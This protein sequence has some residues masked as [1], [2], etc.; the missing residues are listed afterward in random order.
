MDDALLKKYFEFDEADLFANRSGALTDKQ[1]TRLME[2][3]RFARKAFLIAGIVIFAIGIVPGLIP[4]LTGAKREFSIIWSVV[5]IPIWSF[6]A[7]KVIRMGTA[8]K[9]YL[10]VHKAEGKVNIVKEESY[11]SAMKQT[12]DDYELHIG[13]KTFDV[14]SELADVI[15]QGDHYVIYYI[16]GTDDILSAEKISDHKG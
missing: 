5:W 1:R 2:E 12:V 10:K 8:P 14:D 9:N 3:A 13:G 15:M 7:V 4:W 16:D 11:N 6:L